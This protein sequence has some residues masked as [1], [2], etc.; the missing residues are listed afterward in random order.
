MNKIIKRLKFILWCYNNLSHVRKMTIYL[1]DRGYTAN[2]IISEMG[3][4]KR[5]VKKILNK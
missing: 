1:Y 5:L 4:P 2:E 3:Y